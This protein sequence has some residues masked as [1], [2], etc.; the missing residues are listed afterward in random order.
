MVHKVDIKKGWKGQKN[1]IVVDVSAVMRTKY[2]KYYSP[3]DLAFMGPRAK[4]TRVISYNIDGEE[5]NTSSIYGLMQLFSMYGVDNDYIFCFDAPNNLLKQIDKNYKA[6]RVKMGNEYY[7]QVNSTYKMLTEVGFRTMFLGG[8]EGDHHVNKAVKD[9]YA[10]YDNIAIISNDK[11]LS[12]LVDDKVVWVDTLKKRSDIT[13]ENYP[14]VVGCPYNMIALMKAMVGD[15]SDN[16]KGITR[17]GAKSF[18]K[19]IDQEELYGK[20]I[21]S[22]EEQI[23]Q[24][25]VHLTDVQKKSALDSLR[26][27]RFQ[28]V[29]ETVLSEAVP[30]KSI[31]TMLF[32]KYLEMYGMHSINKLFK[33][34][35]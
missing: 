11:D 2:L 23:I 7:D 26:L 4:Y 30:T 3:S 17:F 18:Q 1:L 28:D 19:F 16:I 20:D 24:E 34:E 5:V 27:V 6:N 29:P 32:K 9:N 35:L 21:V 12:Y 13:K 15:A 10:N 31:N 33:I 8:Y 22:K 25:S 14:E